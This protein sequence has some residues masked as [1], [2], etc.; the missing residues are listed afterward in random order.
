MEKSEFRVD[1]A[2]LS[3]G[4]KSVRAKQ[5]LDECYSDSATSERMVKRG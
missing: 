4:K 2:L 5:W 1:K 3:D